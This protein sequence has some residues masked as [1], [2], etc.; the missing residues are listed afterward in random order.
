M[1]EIDWSKA[2]KGAT[3]WT[4]ERDVICPFLRED[5]GVWFWWS[6]SSWVPLYGEGWE[7]QL[8]GIVKRPDLAAWNGAGLPPVGAK[9]ILS[10]ANHDVF[11][12][13][14]E[15]IGVEVTVVASFASPAGFDM[16]ACALPDGLCGCFRADM[17]RPI[18]TPEQIAAEERER[19]IS[20]MLRIYTDGAAG[21]CGGIAA[22]YDAGYRRQEPKE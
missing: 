20:E 13:Y 12:P 22:L 18:R 19:A 15:M 14:K 11:E 5:A 8:R 16:I 3:H 21:H 10:D 2:P 17:A 6:D 9:V 1:K 4:P 7:Y